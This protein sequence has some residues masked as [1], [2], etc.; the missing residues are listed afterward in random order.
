M[1]MHNGLGSGTQLGLAVAR[2]LALL[3]EEEAVPVA[4]LARRV[5]RGRRSAVGIYGFGQGGL[6]VDAGQSTA[7]QIGALACRLAM[8]DD[9]EVLLITPTKGSAGLSGAGEDRAFSRLG[10]MPRPLTDRLC[11]IVLTELLP[12]IQ[13]REFEQFSGALFEYGRLVGEFFAP[14]QGGTFG[15]PQTDVVIAKLG[16][17]GIQGSGQ[18]S[19]GPTV[20]AFVPSAEC[21]QR[22]SAELARM[23]PIDVRC[24]RLRN[25]GATIETSGPVSRR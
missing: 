8:P 3:A 23:I 2:G 22:V 4:E 7:E 11:R 6:I 5:G 9:W 12:A 25:C 21:G 14:V 20:F 19:W 15:D 16:S 17:L 24:S 13:A 1:P 10:S 18:T